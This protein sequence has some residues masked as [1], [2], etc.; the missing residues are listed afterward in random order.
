[1]QL[2]LKFESS[3]PH[4]PAFTGYI[5]FLGMNQIWCQMHVHLR[6][7]SI[8]RWCKKLDIIFDVNFSR[9]LLTPLG[10]F[11]ELKLFVQKVQSIIAKFC[12][13][14]CCTIKHWE[15]VSGSIRVLQVRSSNF[16]ARVLTGVSLT[17]HPW[18]LT[19]RIFWSWWS[20]ST[21]II[22]ALCRGGGGVSWSYCRTIIE[23]EFIVMSGTMHTVKKVSDIPVPSRD[24]TD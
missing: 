7:I 10:A 19:E 22:L 12:V 13:G 23:Q 3:R 18:A 17:S 1:M 4:L 6:V 24:I 9:I 21:T 20:S 2:R 16:L 15:E 14:P 8:S 5:I 11:S